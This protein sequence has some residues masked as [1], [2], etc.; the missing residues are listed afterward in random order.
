VVDADE[1]ENEIL[2][3]R[4][5]EIEVDG[6]CDDD[7][8]LVFGSERET[9]ILQVSE[10]VGEHDHDCEYEEL[11]ENVEEWVWVFDGDVVREDVIDNDAVIESV[12]VNVKVE[13]LL[14]DWE[15]VAVRENVCEEVR[16]TLGLMEH[17]S[18]IDCDFDDDGVSVDETD[19]DCVLEEERETDF[20]IELQLWDNDFEHV[21]EPLKL[22]VLVT[23]CESVFEIE[24]V[25]E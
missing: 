7:N 8:V 4:D 15:N 1:T 16:V 9:V 17:E 24:C 21:D 10:K 23:V 25:Y 5:C 14:S 6:E 22:R 12:H 20:V 3:L 13:V 19:T 18:V 2:E 11:E